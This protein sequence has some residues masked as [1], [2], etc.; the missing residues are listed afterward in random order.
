MKSKYLVILILIIGVVLSGCVKTPQTPSAEEILE[1]PDEAI[2]TCEKVPESD[3]ENCYDDVGSALSEAGL[4]DKVMELCDKTESD[5]CY[6]HLASNLSE[7]G[8]FDKVMEVC[9]KT[10]SDDCYSELAITAQLIDACKKI[11]SSS[12]KRD[13]LFSLA[14]QN[15]TEACKEMTNQFDRNRCLFDIARQTKSLETCGEITD[16]SAKEDCYMVLSDT[17]RSTDPNKAFEACEKLTNKDDCYWNLVLNLK[18]ANPSAALTACSKLLVNVDECYFDVARALLL[19]DVDKA[20]SICGKMEYT[21]NK[22]DCYMM[23]VNR[24]EITLKNPDKAI[25][26][27]GKITTDMTMCYETIA[28]ILT[29]TDKD[30][31][32]EACGYITEDDFRT[33]CE[34]IYG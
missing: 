4:F 8:L 13:C 27:C 2:A 16:A 19:T 7:A 28:K 32:E 22:N 11:S 24:P 20:V 9:D 26:V 21:I 15:N 18:T 17:F 12:T 30:K 14:S 25:E 29:E 6:S 5:D 3:K 34:Q 33:H 31:A 10:E 1:N 23:I